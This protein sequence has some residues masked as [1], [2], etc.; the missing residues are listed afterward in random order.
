MFLKRF[1]GPYSEPLFGV[2]IS[3][4]FQRLI[5]SVHDHKLGWR[6]AC[7]GGSPP[8]LVELELFISDV[9]VQYLFVH[10]FLVSEVIILKVF[11]MRAS[12]ACYV[13]DLGGLLQV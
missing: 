10:S 2:K 7:F 11:R 13:C 6:E 1:S 3:P 12:F 9:A 8:A 4:R 5:D